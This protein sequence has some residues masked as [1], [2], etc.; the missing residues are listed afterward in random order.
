L[1]IRVGKILFLNSINSF[2]FDKIIVLSS[3]EKEFRSLSF[4]K[5]SKFNFNSLS[6]QKYCHLFTKNFKVFLETNLSLIEFNSPFNCSVESIQ[7]AHLM[8]VNNHFEKLLSD[9]NQSTG[10]L[11]INNIDK[12]FNLK[13][14]YQSQ[15]SIF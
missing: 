4:L 10:M 8:S 2:K 1:L 6:H 7:V 12:S 15:F 5:S 11:Y 14:L 9:I 13:F 3:F